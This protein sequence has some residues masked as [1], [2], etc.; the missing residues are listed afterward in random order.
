[1]VISQIADMTKS[2]SNTLTFTIS[3]GDKHVPY[4]EETEMV[5][6]V[7]EKV[8]LTDHGQN[9]VENTSSDRNKRPYRPANLP[10]G[11]VELKGESL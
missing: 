2:Y 10:Q 5:V 8:N 1:M 4:L 3:S 7:R 6:V 9:P 11:F